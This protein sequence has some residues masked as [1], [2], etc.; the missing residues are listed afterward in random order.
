VK[1]SSGKYIQLQVVPPTVPILSIGDTSKN[2]G[3]FALAILN[4]PEKT[5]NGKY[6]VAYVSKTTTGGLLES[7]NK[8][9]G[10]SGLYVQISS[11]KDYDSLWP[12]A[13]EEM[14]GMMKFW[15]EAGEKS[16]SSEDLVHPHELG[17]NTE[18]LMGDEEAFR[19]YDWS[20]L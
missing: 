14:G 7:W 12:G 3:T 10:R 2:L 20:N 19:S 1:S 11:S 8:A 6:V 18:A 5:L 16:W 17:I 9:T 13:G 4:Q 15:E